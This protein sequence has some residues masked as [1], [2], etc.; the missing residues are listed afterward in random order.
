MRQR[1]LTVLT[2]VCALCAAVALAGEPVRLKDDEAKSV[3]LLKSVPPAYPPEAKKAGI[4]GVVKLEATVDKT[5]KV[6]EIKLLESPDDSLAKAAADA[7]KQWEYSPY[8]GKDKKP[9]VFMM[10]VTVKFK[11]E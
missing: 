10:T 3:K 2:L 4:Q 5:G 1:I 8:L 11:L 7:V 9:A 6:S